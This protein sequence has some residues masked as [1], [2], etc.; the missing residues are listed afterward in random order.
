MEA[1]RGPAH[2]GAQSP[3]TGDVS[4]SKKECVVEGISRRGLIA[5]TGAL[6][7]SAAMAS[8]VFADS[9]FGAQSATTPLS[10]FS[11]LKGKSVGHIV[12]DITATFPTRSSAEAQRLGKKYGFDV[13]IVDGAGDYNKLNQA[14]TT[15]ATKKVDAIL[16]TGCDPSLLK[17]GLSA[18]A[19]ANIP[20]GCMV[21]GYGPG[22]LYDVEVNDW[23]SYA[24]LGTYIYNRLGT[25]GDWG[26]AIINWS[27]VPALRIRSAQIKA[28]F[29]Y[30]KTPILAEEEVK[31]PGFVPDAKQKA[32]A[33]LT[34]YPKGRKLKVI[35]AGWDDVGIAAAQAIQE[36]GR[37][38]VFVVSADGNLAA[39]D[40]IRA[41]KPF[42]VTC[43]GDVEGMADVMYGQMSA[44]LGGAKPLA[45]TLYVDAPMITK[46]NVPP[47][48]KYPR[49]AGLTLYT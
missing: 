34:K 42:A 40:M 38:D 48:G 4:Q 27:N 11:H 7:G 5:K 8:S 14:L 25:G 2:G 18:A 13:Q 44:I 28:M 19:S 23:L 30:N 15:F 31:V 33:L 9:A 1:S 12:I 16:N 3:A 22:V 46:R 17:S 32:A 37:K 10:D 45:T 35:V 29:K 21:A 36:A 26:A 49:G 20:V 39:F 24:R 47:K 41:N 6:A 43:S